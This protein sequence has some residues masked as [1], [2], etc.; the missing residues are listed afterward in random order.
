MSTTITRVFDLLKHNL[1]NF[2]KSEFISGKIK[3]EWKKYSTQEFCE[4]T[5]L[6]SR[7][8]T[9]LG[10]GKG[11]RVAV[12]SPNRPEWNICDYA[13]MQLGLIKYHFT[14]PLQNMTLNISSKMQR[15]P[16]FL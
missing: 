11:A 6:L 16:S 9:T 13:I 4:V 1:E 15:L 14:L 8:L 5:D 3:G 12:M 10:I 2:P 7:G